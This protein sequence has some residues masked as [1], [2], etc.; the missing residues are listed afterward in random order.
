M[1]IELPISK[2]IANRVLVRKAL[3]GEDL[4]PFRSTTMPEDVRVMAECLSAAAPDRLDVGNS[5]TAM[6]F[7]TAYYAA[8]EGADLIIDGCARMHERPIGQEVDALRVLGA[9]IEY[10]EKEGFPPLH[11][12][13]R[14]LLQKPVRI[15]NPQSTQF[16]SAL[17][18]IGADVT[19]NISSPYID[20][21]RAIVAGREELEPD[22]S[23]AA[24]WYERRALKLVNALEFPGLKLD[25]LQG[26]KIVRE[27]FAKIEARS[28]RTLDCADFPDLVPAIAVTCHQLHYDLR[29][30]G[31]ES[32]RLKESDRLQALEENFRRIREGQFPLCSYGDHR[33]AMAFLAAGY[34]VDDTDCIR[35]SY[36]RFMEQLL[37]M[38][39][40]IPLP[41][42]SPA[43]KGHD[44]LTTLVVPD[45]GKGKKQAL[46]DGISLAY[47]R[48]VW[49]ND[50]DI[51][52]PGIL[53][54]RL[55]DVDLIILPV[56]MQAPNDSLIEQLQQ[57][58]HAAIQELTV[59][60]ARRGHPIL[61]SGA[62]M[63]V[64]RE[65]WVASWPH[66]HH[67]IP[68]GEDML[69]L[70]SFK[71]RGRRI[72]ALDHYEATCTALPTL[73]ETMRHRM[74]QTA[75]IVHYHDKDFRLFG[76]SVLLSNLL[77][78]AC[79]PWLIGKWVYDTLL[80]RN[81]LRRST[82]DNKKADSNNRIDLNQRV[83]KK[84][85]LK[86]LLLTVLYP[87]YVIVCLI[88]GFIHPNK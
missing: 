87:W 52:L 59:R 8:K 25:S 34:A 66:L 81:R 67:N 4:T 54:P 14:K 61:C 23:A 76:T 24:F 20:M 40:I 70:E 22:W 21:T 79:P 1:N 78:V 7:L 10:T 63:I 13:G 58:E 30:T 48:Y 65:A 37:D 51:T 17:L 75:K 71:R 86:T 68:S 53:P 57:I 35:K 9:D 31:T 15:D 72:I 73:R 84:L 45:R 29:L 32:L 60:Y 27:I 41:N 69:L 39:R 77:A 62:N 80:L 47:T 43:P 5:G 33:I 82:R 74:C 11:I 88:G 26:D 46:Y 28:L 56:R 50:A 19:T 83:L 55:P 6:R 2:S 3:R 49:L 12:R 18:L 85:W 16:V 42:G 36:P 64:N 44:G 38:T